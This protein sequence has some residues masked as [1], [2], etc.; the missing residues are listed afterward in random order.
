MFQPIGL[1]W[2]IVTLVSGILVIVYPRFLRYIVG[3][4]LI[5][6]GLWAIIPRLHF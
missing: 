2:G 3:I 1:V 6:V 5:V 4:Y